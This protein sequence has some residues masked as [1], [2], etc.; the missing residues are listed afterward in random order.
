MIILLNLILLPLL[1]IYNLLSFKLDVN[2][3]L[4]CIEFISYSC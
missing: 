1:A 4:E 2:P 3:W